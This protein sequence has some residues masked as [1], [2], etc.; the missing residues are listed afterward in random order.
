MWKE[1]VSRQIAAYQ[2]DSFHQ[3]LTGPALSPRIAE[4][5]AGSDGLLPMIAASWQ[6]VEE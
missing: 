3:H 6:A 5:M 2:G 1:W 4:A